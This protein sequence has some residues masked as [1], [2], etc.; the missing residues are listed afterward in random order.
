MA[1]RPARTIGVVFCVS[2]AL[3]CLGTITG[4][5]SA[6]PSGGSSPPPS[7]DEIDQA[8]RAVIQDKAAI[9][10]IQAQL[11]AAQRQLT[12][13]D[14]QA[15]AAAEHYDEATVR[16]QSAKATARTAA[17]SVISAQHQYDTAR[18]ELGRLA[19]QAYR[20]GNGFATV[21]MIL[22]SDG[23]Q[24]F[25]ERVHILQT[26]SVDRQSALR[27]AS[28]SQQAAVAAEKSA[29]QAVEAERQDQ[30]QVAAAAQQAQQ[31]VAAEQAQVTAASA[32]RD[33]LVAQLAAAQNTSV[34]LEQQRQQALAA[35][36]AQ[37][38]AQKAAQQAAQ[39]AS[40]AGRSHLGAPVPYASGAAG[41]ALAFAYAQLG[42]P[43]VWGAIGPNSY[44]CSG[45]AMTAYDQA[46]IDLPHFAAFQF[47]ASHPLTYDQLR[48]GDL[49]FWATNPKDSNSIYHEAI[50]IGS[51]QMIQAPKTG[52]DVM[53]SNMWMW[54][55]IQFYARP[56]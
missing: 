6:D 39:Q 36:A 7:Q 22:T 45:L 29:D 23:P 21:T 16:L 41:Q 27:D 9:D 50:Y 1:D 17:V 11:D 38:A 14:Q 44:D 3:A 49:L 34:R 4:G 24:Q 20:D 47:Q 35:A 56:Y 28:Q 43:Y 19:A 13:L 53:I 37:Q 26:Q 33:Q 48:P 51:Q 42:K 54:G 25:V 10:P 55:P 32:R 52:W 8:Q 31:A 15:Q 30:A 18:L 2:V 5:A 46:G 40:S 12:G